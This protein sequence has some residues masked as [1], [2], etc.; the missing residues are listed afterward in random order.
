MPLFSAMVDPRF[1]AMENAE[2]AQAAGN[3]FSCL[4]RMASA[5]PR[6]PSGIRHDLGVLVSQGDL[7]GCSRSAHHGAD[8]WR[9]LVHFSIGSANQRTFSSGL[10]ASTAGYMPQEGQRAFQDA[11]YPVRPR[12]EREKG[13]LRA[14]GAAGGVTASFRESLSSRLW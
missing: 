14:Q 4:R 12:G 3:V 9:V 2:D 11:S 13:S 1:W 6:P 8:P 10:P 7:P 5:V